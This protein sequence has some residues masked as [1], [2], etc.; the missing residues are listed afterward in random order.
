MY[1]NGNIWGVI[2]VF[3]LLSL[4]LGFILPY[5]FPIILVFL[6]IGV[7]RS[8]W[9]RHLIKKSQQEAEKMFRNAYG[10]PYAGNDRRDAEQPRGHADVIDAEYEERDKEDI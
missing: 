10:D 2:L 7:V 8:L 3:F 9:T 6:V 5:L 1:G 4:L